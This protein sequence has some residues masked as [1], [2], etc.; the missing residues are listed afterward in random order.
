MS[1]TPVTGPWSLVTSD[2]CNTHFTLVLQARYM[3]ITPVLN[4]I[5]KAFGQDISS[6]ICT[7]T[8]QDNK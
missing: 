8:S 4:R 1:V 3:A 5:D 2:W 7:S 6:S